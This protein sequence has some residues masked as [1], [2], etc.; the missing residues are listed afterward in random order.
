MIIGRWLKA[1]TSAP[2]LLERDEGCQTVIVMCQ[3]S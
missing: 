1:E 3:N 2:I